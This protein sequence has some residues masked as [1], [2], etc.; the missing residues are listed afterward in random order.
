MRLGIWE[1]TPR[2][3]YGIDVVV[4]SVNQEVIS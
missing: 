4:I 1:I 3:I 2:T